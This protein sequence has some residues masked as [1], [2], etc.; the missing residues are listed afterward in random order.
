MARRNPK[1]E[2]REAVTGLSKFERQRL[3]AGWSPL[4]DYRAARAAERAP[5][6]G[7]LLQIAAV[8]SVCSCVG[9]EARRRAA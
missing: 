3:P 2:Y 8:R 1:R 9:C 6:V 4:D 7:M 5:S